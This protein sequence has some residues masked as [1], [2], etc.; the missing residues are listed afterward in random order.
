MKTKHVAI[1][2]VFGAAAGAPVVVESISKY[3][4]AASEGAAGN[5]VVKDR[6]DSSAKPSSS[7]G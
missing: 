1:L 2:F 4:D 3:A 6:R 7:T 5:R